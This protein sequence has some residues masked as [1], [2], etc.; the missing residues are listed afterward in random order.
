MVRGALLDLPQSQG[1]TS[2]T[3]RK[4]VALGGPIVEVGV[5]YAGFH[6][7]I[8]KDYEGFLFNLGDS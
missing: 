7:K 8:T 3:S 2:T 4:V 1:R 6:Y 5:D